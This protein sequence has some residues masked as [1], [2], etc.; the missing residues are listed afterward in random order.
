M[1]SGGTFSDISD[2]YFSSGT[3]EFSINNWNGTMSYTGADEV[4]TFTAES[5]SESTSGAF[6][7]YED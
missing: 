7:Y 6:F 3:I 5:N 2:K 1:K 4:P